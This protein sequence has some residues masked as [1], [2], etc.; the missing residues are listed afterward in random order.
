MTRKRPHPGMIDPDRIIN[1]T[2]L[3]R[4]GSWYPGSGSRRIE[5]SSIEIDGSFLRILD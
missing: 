4:D 3:D 5:V 1:P 2:D